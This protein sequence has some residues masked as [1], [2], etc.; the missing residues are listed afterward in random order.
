MAEILRYVNTASTAGGDGTTNGTAGATRAYATLAEA[1]ANEQAAF[2]GDYLKILC[3]GSTNDT[4]V[5]FN[6]STFASAADYIQV[7]ANTGNEALKTGIDASRYQ[8]TGADTATI[9]VLDDNIRF[10]NLQITPSGSGWGIGLNT[11]SASND[12]RVSGCYFTFITSMSTARGILNSTE[13]VDD[14]IIENCVFFDLYDGILVGAGSYLFYNNDVFDCTSD[15]I[16]FDLGSTYTIKNSNFGN[17]GTDIDSAGTATAVQYNCAD[18]DLDTIFSE[19]T[20]QQPLSSSWGNEKT[21]VTTG[22]FTAIA[23]GNIEGNGVGPSTDSTVPTTDIDG[24]TRSGTTCDI[25]CD[26]IAGAA[27]GGDF[28]AWLKNKS[29]KFHYTRR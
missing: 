18:D 29:V 16:E 12:I 22:D 8:I 23:G 14:M 7:E 3:D 27:S 17:N 11:L 21:A 15:G 26:E 9:D 28:P 1:E 19:S 6:G 20:N 24:T 5:S 2:S 13:D 4:V 10:V 25:G